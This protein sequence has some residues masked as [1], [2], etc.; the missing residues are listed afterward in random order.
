MNWLPDTV[1]LRDDLSAVALALEGAHDPRILRYVTQFLGG[2]ARSAEDRKLEEETA[3]LLNL[4]T[5]G[6]P[7]HSQIARVATLVQNR[8]A[9]N[10]AL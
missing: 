2:V 5:D 4:Q 3:T 8:I 1:A 6:K 7:V 10:A 9:Q